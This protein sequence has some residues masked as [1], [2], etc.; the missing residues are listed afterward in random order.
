MNYEA[1]KTSHKISFLYMRMFRDFSYKP[2]DLI[3]TLTYAFMH[4]F[5]PCNFSIKGCNLTLCIDTP[6]C[7]RAKEWIVN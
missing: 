4:N 1:Y 6:E 5:C 3:P 2:S 7:D